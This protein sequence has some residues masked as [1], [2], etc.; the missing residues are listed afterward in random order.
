MANQHVSLNELRGE[1][2]PAQKK[3]SLPSLLQ[4]KEV[5]DRL[6]HVATAYLTPERLTSLAVNAIARTPKL[7]QCTPTSVLGAVMASAAVGLEPNTVA[8]QAWLI[9]YERRY[10]QGGQWLSSYE[11]QFQIGYRGYIT[12]AYRSPQ[13]ETLIAEAVHENDLFEHMQGSEQFCRYR[14]ALTHRGDLVAS[15]CYTRLAR[16]ES[17]TVLPLDEVL[18]I[19]EYSETYTALRRRVEAANSQKDRDVAQ[20]KFDETPWV[21]ALDDMAAKSA[22]RKHMKR[23]PWEY[24]PTDRF[25]TAVSV[26]ADR[27]ID[28]RSLSN[29]DR[30]REVMEGAPAPEYPGEPEPQSEPDT[31]YEPPTQETF[32]PPPAVDGEP[33]PPY[34]QQ[35]ASTTVEQTP[36]AGPGVDEVLARIAE[37]NDMDR[38]DEAVSL[39]QELAGTDKARVTK[40]YKRRMNEIAQSMGLE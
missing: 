12:L 22:I 33:G 30:M 28:Y 17:V 37:A 24:D 25:G 27:P 1:V 23:L 20:R 31:G 36:D 40:A 26:D 14:K 34:N 10:K 39:G 11:C 21:A 19:R 16:G 6:A 13:I 29:P 7:A 38:L 3:A 2:A 18:R 9:P 32:D 4:S 5:T 8:Q 35:T 15:F